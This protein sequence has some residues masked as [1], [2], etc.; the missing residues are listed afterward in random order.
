MKL[1][2][3]KKICIAYLGHPDLDTRV[4]NLSDSLKN[5]GYEVNLIGFNFREPKFQ[6]L[7]LIGKNVYKLEKTRIPFNFYFKFI[8]Y[9]VLNLLKIKS[10]IYIAEDVYTLPFVYIFGRKRNAKVIYNSREIYAHL[11]GLRNRKWVQKIIASIEK[12]Y[13]GKVDLVLTTGEMDTEFLKEEYQL[14]QI[15]TIRNLPKKEKS[16]SPFNF[17]EYYNIAE[18]K[19]VIIYQGVIL[20]GRGLEPIMKALCQ[21]DNY[22][23]V[24]LGEGEHK[25][26]YINLAFE[27]GVNKKVFFHGSIPQNELQ[28]YTMGGDV[29]ISL[30]ENISVSYYYALPNKLFEYIMAGLPVLVSDLPQMKKIVYDFNVGKVVPELNEEQI[31]KALNS[32]FENKEVTNKFISNCEKAANVLNW[33]NEYQKFKPYLK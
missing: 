2:V 25:Q 27:L 21:K 22:V 19:K 12:R 23:L 16:S 18:D 5:D 8:F 9:L 24:V 26:K 14:N 10:D 15:I 31:L 4:T 11:A 13:I 30:I 28:K 32:V 3:G 33:E 7:K 1:A 29:G 17:R 20:E 6:T